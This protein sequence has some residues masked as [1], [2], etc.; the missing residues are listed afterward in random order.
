MCCAEI[1][2]LDRTG[3]TFHAG[4]GKSPAVGF[5]LAPRLPAVYNSRQ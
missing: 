5:A 2:V 1:Q 4:D 3:I